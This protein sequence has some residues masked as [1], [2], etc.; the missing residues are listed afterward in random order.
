MPLPKPAGYRQWCWVDRLRDVLDLLAKRKDW[1]THNISWCTMS[2]D[3][4]IEHGKEKRKDYYGSK[5]FDV[6][7]RNHGS[8]PW[9]QNS[10]KH[11]KT[12]K[13]FTKE[14]LDEMIAEALKEMVD[15]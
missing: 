11:K 2:L 4:A 12:R 7:C 14:E 5:R 8:C 13:F 3:K 15:K 9:C 1:L 6:T 10:I